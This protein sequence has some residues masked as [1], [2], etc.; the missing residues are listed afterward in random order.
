MLTRG[1]G[2]EESIAQAL[3]ELEGT[4]AGGSGGIGA[5]LDGAQYREYV[6][7]VT[8]YQNQMR[9]FGQMLQAIEGRK[10]V[11]FFSR[12]FD[13]MVMA[14]QTLGQM[15][16][17][18]DSRAASPEGITAADPEMLYGTAEIRDNMGEL[19]DMFR[20]ADAAIHAIDPSG[21]RALGDPST[22]SG[23]GG[24]LSQG[25]DSQSLGMR[26]G[27]QALTALAVGTD[28]SMHLN[29]NDLS[30]ALA[31]IEERTAAF[32]MIG[33][34]KSADDPATV[35]VEV[36]VRVPGVKIISAPRALTPPPDYRD[37]N[38]VQRQL[39][40]AE[41]LNDDVERRQISFDS[42]V[43]AFPTGA[44]TARAALLVEVPGLEIDSLAR[45]RGGDQV[46]FEIAA[47]AVDQEET[48]LDEVRRRVTIDVEQ[49]RAAGPLH[50]QSFRYS[51]LL[52]V[53]AGT[54]RIRMLLREAEVGLLSTRTMSFWAGATDDRLR[55]MRPLVVGGFGA[56]APPGSDGEALF[57]PLSMNGR[58]L[59]FSAAPLLRPGA[60]FR[61]LVVAYH[62][63]RDPETG[64]VLAGL[65]LE[66]ED[67]EGE[68]YRLTEWEILGSSHD[69]DRDVT[70]LLVQARFPAAVP[71]GSG[72]LWVRFVDRS[73][74]L[75]VEEQTRIYVQG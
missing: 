47:F 10:N 55:I 69:A 44:D 62:V 63:P 73:S 3:A 72:H 52:D 61:L 27:R 48:I 45:M 39:Q 6:A 50:E 22:F 23:P 56:P 58:R 15:A 35:D 13:D 36:R 43:I 33:Y 37:M 25:F 24:D 14:G 9:A 31:D 4:Q 18:S 66:A 67:G 21:A 57:D 75:R 34:S 64:E 51:D 29:L 5:A 38:P 2:A 59:S 46:Q 32:Y 17:A 11:L 20:Q 40:L 54:Y 19:V 71:T 70:Q 26:N 41:F 60:P 30:V 68:P 8:N 53:P 1:D 65:A 12:G 28:G 42:Q 7:T 74:G 49:L 16:S